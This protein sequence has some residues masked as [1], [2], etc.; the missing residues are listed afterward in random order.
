ML[1]FS[2]SFPKVFVQ[3]DKKKKMAGR[4]KKTVPKNK[5]EPK[6]SARLMSK[7]QDKTENK[8]ESPEKSPEKSPKK[9]PDKSPKKSVR[10][11]VD[12]GSQ[13]ES[14]GPPARSFAVPCRRG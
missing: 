5:I 7:E 12:D 2:F 1:S 4:K 10:L 3:A 14:A 8:T 11:Q 6:R 9:S 13:E